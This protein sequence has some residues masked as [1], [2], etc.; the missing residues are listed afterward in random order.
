MGLERYAISI[1]RVQI[2]D[3]GM[4]Q[5]SITIGI[6]TY[7]YYLLFMKTAKDIIPMGNVFV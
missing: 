3:V 5:R 2:V 1:A 4:T 7:V 6:E